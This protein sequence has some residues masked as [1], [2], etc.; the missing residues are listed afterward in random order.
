MCLFST[1][2]FMTIQQGSDQDR[3][4]G[5]ASMISPDQRTNEPRLNR[6]LEVNSCTWLPSTVGSH[7]TINGWGWCSY[8]MRMCVSIYI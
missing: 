8:T 7:T 3:T 1:W 4:G 6:L 5:Q 2:P